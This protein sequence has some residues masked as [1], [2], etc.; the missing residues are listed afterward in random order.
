[1]TRVFNLWCFGCAEFKRRAQVYVDNMYSP[2]YPGAHTT[3]L[4]EAYTYLRLKVD[5]SIS[6]TFFDIMAKS[7]ARSHPP[8]NLFPGCVLF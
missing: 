4:E 1:M 5:Y 2:I 8:G 7:I 3:V 6:D